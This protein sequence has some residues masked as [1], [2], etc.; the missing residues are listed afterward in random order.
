MRE[1]A[2]GSIIIAV[3][4][5]TGRAEK[6]FSKVKGRMLDLSSVAS[7]VGKMIASAFA[8][9]E[10][11][12]FG[13]ECIE[14]G[15]NV[16][17]VQNVVD[18]AFGDMAYKIE[19]FS[20]TAIKQFGMSELAAKKT[21]S[22]Y[23]AMARGMGIQ[24]A[25]AADMAITLTGLTGDIASFFNI[26]Q[27]LA[28]IKLKSVFTGETETLKD[29]GIV[30]TE[31]N[32]EAFALS[33][34][35]KKSFQN[36]SQSEKVALRY[37]FVMEQLSLVHGD[38]AK[39][40][41][42]WANQTRILSMQWQEFMSI[43]GQT[44]TTVFK[45][46]ISMLNT[47]VS[48]LIDVANTV[49]SVVTNIFGG[50]NTQIQKTQSNAAEIS[51]AIGD[52][53]ENQE[54]LTA[55]TKETAKAQAGALAGFDE[56]N[57]LGSETGNNG[58]TGTTA[59]IGTQ[60][61]TSPITDST[62]EVE[63]LLD[64]ILSTIQPA[65]DSIMTLWDALKTVGMFAGDALADFY[66]TELKPIGEWVI[67]EGFPRFVDAISN[68]LS[69]VDWQH[70]ND[71]LHTLWEALAPFAVNVGEGLLWLWEN[72]LVPFGTWVM[73]DVVPVFIEGI[74]A[75]LDLFNAIWEKAKPGLEWLW[76]SFLKPVAEWTGGVIV[77]TLERL[78]EILG[79]F[80]GVI[81]GEITFKEFIE[82]L[83]NSEIAFL[84]LV[85]AAGAVAAALAVYNTAM[86][87]AAILTGATVSPI[88]LVVAAVASLI[89]AILLCIKNWDK[90]KEAAKKAVDTIV[91]LWESIGDW[92]N[93]HVVEPVS[94]T[95]E[96]LWD[97]IYGWASDAWDGIKNTFSEVS[98]WFDEKVIQPVTAGFKD[99]VNGLIGFVESFVNFFVRG[100]NTV[101]DSANKLR[102]EIPDWV[103]GIGGESF[104]FNLRRATEIS[105]PRLATGS[106]VPPNR[107][108][109]AILG[110]NKRETEVVSPLSTMKQ[111]MLEA[112]QE[113]GGFGG[114][115]YKFELYVNGRRMAVEMVKEINT[116]TQQ[117][118]KP[119]L[120]I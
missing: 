49:N 22:T 89:A 29:L 112:L 101:I 68:G 76:E 84:S 81:S 13:K 65:I 24:E 26:S 2:D 38:F 59:V 35:I 58:A 103:P 99:F 42:S 115:T 79:D 14:L 23:M 108:F 83:D 25:A 19:A 72:V 109:M 113:S 85:I 40:S 80:A 20:D 73:N 27:E 34:G 4:V 114:G 47:V 64:N 100:I 102:F 87:L 12:Q 71:A 36:M 21:A 60:L 70:I 78:I 37:N 56:I 54:A 92:F 104:G 48:S 91:D 116:M 10:I 97:S 46:L 39:T 6:G 118:G 43:I 51:D 94:R 90:I 18:T 75:A 93:D 53:V 55:A 88:L 117:A 119:V 96:N 95:F 74:A 98:G 45:P 82:G 52:S 7:K 120:L 62:K 11:A 69:L 5:D 61:D 67:G 9:R 86:A 106:V 33:K 3:D 57:K 50:A 31:T 66:E 30:M 77:D 32:L 15:S 16:A 41:D 107:E 44:L 63:G 17:E 8:I 28:D 105:L 110:D 1:R 111:A